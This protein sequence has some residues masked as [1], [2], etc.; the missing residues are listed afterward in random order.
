MKQLKRVKVYQS[1]DSFVADLKKAINGERI[2]T[3][4]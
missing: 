3:L 2:S 1:I 4:G